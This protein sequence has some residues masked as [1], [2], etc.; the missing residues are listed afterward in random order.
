MPLLFIRILLKRD[1]LVVIWKW[2]K[3]NFFFLY[4]SYMGF[5]VPG[6]TST[7]EDQKKKKK[8]NYQHRSIHYYFNHIINYLWFISKLMFL[9]SRIRRYHLVVPP[10]ATALDWRRQPG[11]AEQR[12]RNCRELWKHSQSPLGRAGPRKHYRTS[13]FHWVFQSRT[14]YWYTHRVRQ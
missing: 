9:M 5:L 14:T 10:A 1:L 6:Y 3:R 12:G 8:R 2:R 7:V 4:F 13:P 11:P